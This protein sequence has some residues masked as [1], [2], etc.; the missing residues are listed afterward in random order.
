MVIPHL[1]RLES[2][3]VGRPRLVGAG[4]MIGAVIG[5]PL[6]V[7]RDFIIASCVNV[8]VNVNHNQIS[9]GGTAGF[10]YQQS[11]QSA[12]RGRIPPATFEHRINL[13]LEIVKQFIIAYQA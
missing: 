13:I 8:N 7:V 3:M 6:G 12:Y 10:T 4:D 5:L 11:Y 1:R 9:G 2:V